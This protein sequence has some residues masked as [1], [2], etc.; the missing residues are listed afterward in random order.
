[1]SAFE[2]ESGEIVHC[3]ESSSDGEL[4]GTFELN[5]DGIRTKIYGYEKRFFIK[6]EEPVFSL[7]RIIS[8]YRCTQIFQ[9]R[10]VL[11]HA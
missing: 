9:P 3:I 11:I 8:P 1:M 5:K 10:R 6:S 4:T 7:L 2:I